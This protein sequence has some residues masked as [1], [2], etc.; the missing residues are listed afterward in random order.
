MSA[1]LSV[2]TESAQ[3]T[4]PLDFKVDK[5]FGDEVVA[6]LRAKVKADCEAEAER[7]ARENRNPAW[8]KKDRKPSPDAPRRGRRSTNGSSSSP[9]PHPNPESPNPANDSEASE[10]GE[11]LSPTQGRRGRAFEIRHAYR[12]LVGDI[13]D[14]VACC[15]LGILD[16]PDGGPG[17]AR[18]LMSH[19]TGA[20]RQSNVMTCHSPFACTVCAPKV[21]ARRALALAPQLEAHVVEGRTVSLLTLTARHGRRHSLKDVHTALRTAWSR[22]TSGKWWASLRKAGA[23][24]YVRGYDVTWSE[25]HGWHPHIHVTLSLGAEHDD[26][27]VCEAILTRWQN[28]LTV[29][30]WRTTRS[31]QHYHRADDPKAAARYAVTPAAVYESLAMAMK[32]AR[33]EGAGM[34]PFEIV[35][36]AVTDK[37]AG[38]Q[39]SRWIALWREYVSATKGL[40][41]VVTSQDLSLDIID[42]DEKMVEDE[43]LN[44]GAE[45]LKEMDEKN[46]VPLVFNAMENH[47]G[48]PEAVREAVAK[49]MSVMVSRDWSIPGWVGDPHV[50]RTEKDDLD[51]RAEAIPDPP[52]E[53]AARAIRE[54]AA[55]R[56]TDMDIRH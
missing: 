51:H 50:F 2:F 14:T 55:Q 22:V 27:D 10:P 31:A 26:A 35:E 34:T 33:G 23:V 45:A 37:A 29:L 16:N 41:Q 28:A 46:L 18:H 12:S 4:S 1:S 49:V 9:P 19:K 13:H 53:V 8:S 15:G 3:T 52:E 44:A 42:E 56:P 20:V 7:Q 38:V 43:V 25:K 47:V 11:I 36:L 40:R 6:R 5:Y 39:G 24:S 48:D 17:L 54:R 32:R 30:G 21:A